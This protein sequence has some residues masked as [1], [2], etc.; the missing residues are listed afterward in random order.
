MRWLPAP[1]HGGLGAVRTVVQRGRA[2]V[3]ML[4]PWRVAL[5]AAGPRL[6]GPCQL[7]AVL[8]G[9]CRPSLH[10]RPGI[11]Q[12]FS[13][14]VIFEE[15]RERRR[16]GAERRRKSRALGPQSPRPMQGA[17]MAVAGAVSMC[18]ARP[19]SPPVTQVWVPPAGSEER[20]RGQSEAT[21]WAG[22]SVCAG[23][24]AGW[25]SERQVHMQRWLFLSW[26]G[27]LPRPVLVAFQWD[28]A[29]T[30]NI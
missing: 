15:M 30:A 20:G 24:Q 4:R 1:T 8:H 22:A 10:P 2:S 18:R 5:G 21:G 14:Q 19:A 11:C 6:A 3:A 26:L 29:G 7:W 27:A 13:C 25:L 28:R 23:D 9:L 17:P 16:C 12:D